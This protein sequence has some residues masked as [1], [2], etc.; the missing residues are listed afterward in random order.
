[1]TESNMVSLIM[2]LKSME[3]NPTVVK[4]NNSNLTSPW[5]D[6]G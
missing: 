6:S 1:M 3:V 5:E 2:Q 4:M